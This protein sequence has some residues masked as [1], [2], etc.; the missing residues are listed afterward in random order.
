MKCELRVP[1]PENFTKHFLNFEFL[2]NHNRNIAMINYSRSLARE[3]PIVK[4]GA[5]DPIAQW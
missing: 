5:F 4:D 1:P 3:K 2:F